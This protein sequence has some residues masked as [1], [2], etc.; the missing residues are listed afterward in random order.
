[1]VAP[2]GQTWNYS[3]GSPEVIGAVLK[4]ATGEP[5]DELSRTLLFAPLRVTDVKLSITHIS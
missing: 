2:P 5:L 3:S 4:K 1:V